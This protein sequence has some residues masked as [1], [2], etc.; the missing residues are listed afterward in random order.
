[1]TIKKSILIT[2][3]SSGIGFEAAKALQKRGYH[4]IAT[5]RR[6]DDVARLIEQ[7]FDAIE[8]DVDRSESIQAAAKI[9][10][11]KT[12]N[13]L[14][15]IFNNAGFG[16][17]GRM[18]TITRAQ[19]EQQ[20]S[21]NLFGVHELTTLLLPAMLKNGAGRVIQTSSVMGIISTPGRGAYA[22]SK[23]AL[24]AWT[25]AMRLEHYRSGVKFCLIEP[26]P[27][28]TRFKDNVNQVEAGNRVE[29]P[30]IAERLGLGPEAV[31]PKLIHALESKRPKVRYR[32]TLL[33]Q[34]V[35]ILKR[36]L[37]DKW[38]DAILAGK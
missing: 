12:Q 24:E 33:T 29:N 13:Q 25:D 14:Y 1:M 16:V 21:T 15:A 11:E 27:L 7:G 35:A 28:S 18:Q 23:Y 8:L 30:A 9:V 6:Q 10:L 38:M 37:P 32:V 17:Y 22:A 3:C 31:I 2:G 19:L 34:G 20:F 5:C 26:G 36:C 4:V